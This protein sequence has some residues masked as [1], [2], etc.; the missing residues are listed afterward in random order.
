MRYFLKYTLI[1]WAYLPVSLLMFCAPSK[2]QTKSYDFLPR[3]PEYSKVYETTENDELEIPIKG[4]KRKIRGYKTYAQY[5]FDINSGQVYTIPFLM[6]KF[7]ESVKPYLKGIYLQ[8]ESRVIYKIEFGGA[9][10]LVIYEV[11]SDALHYSAT[12]LKTS[13]IKQ[14]EDEIDAEKI[15]QSLVRDGHIALY[16]NFASGDSEL[17]EDAKQVVEQIHKLMIS[18]SNLRLIVEGHTDNV[19]SHEKNKRLSR[20]RANAVLKYL[21][22]KGINQNRLSAKGYGP[23]KPISDN[24]TEEGRRKNRRVELVKVD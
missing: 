1:G 20:E 9:N 4:Q 24:S 3:I 18:K 15:Y 22:D 23:D 8:E 5:D 16:I 21:I 6:S 7:E 12:V 10:L 2:A 17:T 11:Y 14:L 13:G 19:G